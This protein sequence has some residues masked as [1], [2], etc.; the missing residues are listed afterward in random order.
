MSVLRIT[1]YREPKVQ[2]SFVDVKVLWDVIDVGLVVLE[3]NVVEQILAGD[4]DG[5]EG[6]LGLRVEDQA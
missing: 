2:A 1:L 3:L 4:L 5:L 6:N